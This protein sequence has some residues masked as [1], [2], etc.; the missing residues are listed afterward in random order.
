VIF[1][2]T[3][4]VV[5][6]LVREAATE[7]AL[8]RLGEDAALAVWWGTGV[9]CSSAL[10]RLE[11]ESALSAADADRARDV[12]EALE[13][14]AFTLQ[15]TDDVRAHARRVVRRHALTAADAL[16]L[17]AA[18]TWADARPQGHRFRTLDRRLAVAARAEGFDVEGLESGSG[19]AP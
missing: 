19:Q 14:S 6:L 10:A 2:D 4:A 1:W 16:Q 5:P 9:E 7:P 13:R 3:S 12:L 8:A 17:A 18:L 11:R 15:A